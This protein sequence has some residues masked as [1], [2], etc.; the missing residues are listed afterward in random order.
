MIVDGRRG[1]VVE[2]NCE[3]DFVARSG[4]FRRT[5]APLAPAALA[6]IGRQIAMH[7]AASGPRWV[8]EA[9][10]PPALVDEKRAELPAQAGTT[11]KPEG[12]VRAFVRYRAGGAIEP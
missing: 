12:V 4:E 10:I 5:V 7:V 6:D 1:A 11:G 8:S 9:A 3:S 2:V